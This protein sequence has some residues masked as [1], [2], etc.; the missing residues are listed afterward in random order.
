[1]PRTMADLTAPPIRVDRLLKEIL[2]HSKNR[3][4]LSNLTTPGTGFLFCR[5]SPIVDPN[6]RVQENNKQM[7]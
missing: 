1:M 5:V 2:G 6:E 7:E 3:R 4:V